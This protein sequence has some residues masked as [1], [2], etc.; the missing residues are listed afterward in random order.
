M[1]FSSNKPRFGGNKPR[2]N[3]SFRKPKF[4]SK[5]F[6]PEIFVNKMTEVP[7]EEK[8]EAKHAFSDFA[9]DQHL[10]DAIESRGYEV[11]SPIQDQSIP[12]ALQGKDVL[13]IANTGTGKTAAFLIPLIDKILKDRSQKVLILAP[14]R[15][16][17]TQIQDELRSFTNRMGIYSVLC[18]GGASMNVQIQNLRRSYSFVIATPGRLCDLVDQRCVNLSQFQNVVLDEVDHMFD[19]GFIKDVQ[20]LLSKLPQERQSLFFSATLSKEVDKLVKENLQNPTIISL[21]KRETAESVDQDIV[22]VSS[23]AKKIEVLHDLLIQEDF[24]KVLI[25]GRTKR[26]VHN[27]SRMLEERGFRVDAIHGDKTQN[28][29]QMALDKFKKDKVTILVATDVAARGI[30][31]PDVSHVI[32]YEL[33]E[34]YDD[35][36]HRIGRTG[37]ADKLGKALTFVE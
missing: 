33:P 19:M 31:I 35:Y 3:S 25:F 23:G 28:A 29:R 17:A 14:T 11:P 27:L 26:G 9:I 18:I 13:G 34:S 24:T 4:S 30:D 12:H 16:L 1:R 21:K 5:S 7:E 10:K 15:E 8:Y 2:G 36:I 32:N 6:D 22:R 37:R 20:Y